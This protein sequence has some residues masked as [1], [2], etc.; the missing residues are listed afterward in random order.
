M[1]IYFLTKMSKLI[2]SVQGDD[3]DTKLAEVINSADVNLP[4][5]WVREGVY[6]FNGKV[7]FSFTLICANN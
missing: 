5:V 3:I 2:L 7:V 4:F 1:W 6:K